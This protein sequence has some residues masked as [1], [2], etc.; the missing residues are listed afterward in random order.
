MQTLTGIKRNAWRLLLTWA[1]V[2]VFA[3]GALAEETYKIGGIFSVTGRASF[4]GDPEKKSMEMVIEKINAAGGI[5]GRKLEAV[6]YDTE[7]DPTKA[8]MSVSKLLNKDNVLAIIGPS[9]TPTTLAVMPF[10]EKAGTPLISCAAGNKI[11]MPINPWVFKTAQSDIH[12]VQAIYDHM[13]TQ[14]IR[15][16]GILTVA[17]A[18]GE[19]G[20]EQLEAQAGD[21]GLTIVQADKFGGNDTDMTAQLTKIKSAKPDAVICWGTNPGPAVVNKNV[22]QLG[23]NIPVYQSHGVASPK[24]I[25]LAG[26]SAEGTL[27]P[28]GKILIYDLLPETDPQKVVLAEYARTYTETFKQPVSGFGGYAYDAVNILA[29]ALKGTGGD[30]GKLRENL[31]SLTG[32]VGVSGVFNFGPKEHNGLAA[33]AFVMVRIKN[34]TWELVQ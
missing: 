34:G 33:D 22:R 28:T 4:L 31:E 15:K 5:D 7:G 32:H 9:T 20:R 14:G 29:Q 8:V 25:E 18:F 30:K 24:F 16:I 13:K 26:E 21:F 11:T 19:S 3:G 17:D 12:A 27:L 6:I 23:L 2:T 10:A 1:A